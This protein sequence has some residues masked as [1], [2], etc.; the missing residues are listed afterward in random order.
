LNETETVADDRQQPVPAYGWY[1]LGVLFLVYLVNFVDRQIL[2]ILANDIKA[3]LG[4]TDAEL[5]FLYG[6]AF[7]IFYAL[8]G[9]PLG[10]LADGWSRTRLLALG[11]ALW[12]CMT[13]LS[14]FA[15]NG[16]ALAVARVGVGVGEATASPCAYSLIADWFPQRLRATALAIYS[17]GLF[18]GSGLSLLIGGAIVESWNAAWPAGGPL[19]LVGWQAAFL[20]VGLPGLL[21]AL[22]VLSLREPVRGAIDGLPSPGET[23]IW[24]R[25]FGQVALIVPPFT[26]LGAARRGVGALAANLAVA[27]LLAAAAA[28]LARASG[29]PGQ[30]W[31]VAVG[32]YAVFSWACALRADD[33]ATFALT[34]RTPAFIGTVLAYAVV[35][36]IGYTVSYW[37]AP[38]AERVFGYDKVTLGWLLGAPAA[39]GGFLGV[40]V[41]GWLADRLARRFGSG[42][43]MVVAIGLV[44]P[45]PLV[46]I[47]YSTADPALFFVCSFLVQAATASALGA[48]AAAS[49]AL[50][51]PRMRGIATAIFFVGTTLIGLAFGPYTA[52]LVSELTGE[53]AIG[54]I[55]NLALVPVG[56]IA[57]LAAIRLYPASEASRLERAG[58]SGE[59]ITSA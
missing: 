36:F 7:A 13:A 43:L 50:V 12:S 30:F 20:A 4:L 33:P 29:N 2:S 11:L 28:A 32:Y 48:S 21:L 37:A 52:G 8:F 27:G 51:L 34:W 42:R 41:G 54:V 10:R 53:L 47:G 15:R 31:L 16:V 9:I 19:G 38:Y 56:V 49:Q 39:A 1:A 59:A 6:T 5:G 24:R 14:G 26:L 45:V 17:A 23:G 44:V 40:I 57:L 35:C 25:F 22:W 58:K 3:D 18:V 55:G 46:L